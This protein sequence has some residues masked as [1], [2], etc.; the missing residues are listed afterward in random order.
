M[1]GSDFDCGWEFLDELN[2]WFELD[3]QIACGS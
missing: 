1:N 2:E 3:L